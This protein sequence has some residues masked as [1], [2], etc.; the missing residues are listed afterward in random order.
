M[1]DVKLD[2]FF[3][4]IGEVAELT[5]LEPY[6]LRYW[7]T[8][9]SFKLTKTKNN[10]RLYQQKDIHKIFDIKKL[11]Y[12]EKYTIAG[13]K[14]KLK[15]V[16]KDSKGKAKPKNQLSFLPKVKSFAS[17]REAVQKLHV[18]IQ[19]VYDLLDQD[20]KDLLVQAPKS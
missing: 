3:Y 1:A 13:A 8:E 12:E 11:L 4:K 7:E 6:V 17:D 20:P 16:S 18:E 15:E 9:F 10:Q 2:K 19:Q 5:Q 14:K